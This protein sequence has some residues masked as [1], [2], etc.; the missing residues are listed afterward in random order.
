MPVRGVHIIISIYYISEF[1]S[2]PTP[3]SHEEE[4]SVA[5]PFPQHFSEK[6]LEQ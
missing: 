4:A 5:K 2:N 6:H 3:K 1:V